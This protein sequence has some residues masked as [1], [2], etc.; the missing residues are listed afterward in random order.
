MGPASPTPLPRP[1]PASPTPLLSP[2]LPV[3][4]APRHVLVRAP[5]AT[6][7][8]C[9]VRA[10]PHS[11]RSRVCVYTYVC[12]YTCVCVCVCAHAEAQKSGKRGGQTPPLDAP[13]TV[14]PLCARHFPAPGPFSTADS[15]SSHIIHLPLLVGFTGRFTHHTPHLSLTHRTPHPIPP[16]TSHILIAPLT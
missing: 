15:K 6:P 7:L 4:P 2:V 14:P 12:V 11:I 9:Q 16:L 1:A 13:T 3:P 8:P 5:R 10:P